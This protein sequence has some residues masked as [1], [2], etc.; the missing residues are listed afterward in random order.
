MSLTVVLVV[1]VALLLVGIGINS[2]VQQ[3][4]QQAAERRNRLAQHRGCIRDAQDLLNLSATI[5]MDNAV[6]EVLLD[7]ISAHLAGIKGIDPNTPAINEYQGW[8]E[9]QRQQLSA[10]PVAL[11]LPGNAEQLTTLR[12][13]VQRLTEFI[14][15][16]RNEPR[17]NANKVVQAFQ[18]MARVRLRCDIEGH[19]KIGQMAL[20]G[21]QLQLARQYFKYAYDR[22][23]KEN[24]SDTYVQEQLAV[25][26][27]LMNELRRE[28]GLE[29]TGETPQT[30]ENK[31]EKGPE[32]DPLF[33]PKKKW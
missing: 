10:P 12:V 22:L 1:I 19:I 29:L 2:I 15:R 7:Y 31:E 30:E 11:H 14:A 25:L 13:Q 23:V 26:E 5:P 17:L 18:S 27:Q 32:L 21:K 33:A 9:A 20:V 24:V 3:R 4:E 28:E 16:L 6:R 8:V